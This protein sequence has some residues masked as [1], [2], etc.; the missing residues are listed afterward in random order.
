MRRGRRTPASRLVRF[1]PSSPA[2]AFGLVA[3]VACL[4]SML[5]VVTSE[6]TGL[7]QE[8]GGLSHDG[9]LQLARS[10]LAGHGFV[11]E[12]GGDPVFHR[13][14]LYPLLLVPVVALPEP[15][16]RPVLVVVQSALLG[17]VA[18]L[19]WR[20][21]AR[22]FGEA[23]GRLAVAV[24]LLN[25]W[26]IWVVK[27]PH[28][29][30]LQTFLYT[31]FCWLLVQAFVPAGRDAGGGDAGRGR[32][33]PAS[34]SSGRLA[35]L[36]GL[37]G[38][39]LALVHGTMLVTCGVLLAGACLWWL[40][41]GDLRSA[42]GAIAAVVLMVALVA[43]WTAR[44]WLTFGAFIPVVGNAG[45]SYFLGNAHWGIGQDPVRRGETPWEAALRH[46]GADPGA[47]AAVRFW[48]LTDPVLDPE[49]TRRMLGHVRGHPDEV[50][51][52]VAL[53]AG[54]YYFPLLYP[55]YLRSGAPDAPP[56]TSIVRANV[57]PAAITMFHGVLWALCVA[58]LV[59]RRR[60]RHDVRAWWA[61]VGLVAVFPL[62]YLPF[63]VWVGHALYALPT[64][65]LL[66]VLGSVGLGA[67]RRREPATIADGVYA[68]R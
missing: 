23:A 65:P 42:A 68:V 37:N 26:L 13:P 8:F 15:W 48:G 41:T 20:I 51:R 38:G 17:G 36:L 40:R 22:L 46:A 43:P 61:V 5:V 2:T 55:L 32:L 18:A 16:Q 12:A 62:G 47:S 52:K 31:S 19:V 29:A 30:V 56:W 35:L 53:N 44:N 28:H 67:A 63:L 21:G 7:S 64:I 1:L 50:L 34:G 10:L 25:P 49:M 33:R 59:R 24:M 9:Y 4:T 11:F 6:W 39:A 66:S 3:T 14:P 60:D 58:A 27:N 45:F 57:R 54:E